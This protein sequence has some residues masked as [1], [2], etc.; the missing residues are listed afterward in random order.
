MRTDKKH[1][2]NCLLSGMYLMRTINHSNTSGYKMYRDNMVPEFF[3]TE[4]SF[5]S[6]E[7]NL[8]ISLF[9][10]DSKKRITLNLSGVRQLHGNHWIK[11]AYQKRRKN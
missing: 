8:Y 5:K 2:I 11:K 7:S 1:V 4:R 9:K 10:M 3:I 6:L